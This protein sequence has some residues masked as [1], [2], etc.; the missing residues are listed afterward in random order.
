MFYQELANVK[1]PSALVSLQFCNKEKEHLPGLE[2]FKNL[3]YFI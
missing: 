2:K 3:V 1:N